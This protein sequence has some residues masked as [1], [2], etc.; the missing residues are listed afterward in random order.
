M[1]FVIKTQNI[2]LIITC[3]ITNTLHTNFDTLNSKLEIA[4]FLFIIMIIALPE[5]QSYCYEL[6][7]ICF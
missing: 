3:R 6:L 7:E 1:K 2:F 5:L 4:E